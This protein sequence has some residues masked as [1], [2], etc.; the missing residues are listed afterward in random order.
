M[1]TGIDIVHVPYKAMQQAMLDA[2]TGQIQLSYA[3]SAQI[4]P[5]VSAGKVKPIAILGERRYPAW[6]AVGT[7]RDSLPAYEPVPS[8]TACGRPQACRS[9][10]SRG[11]P[12]S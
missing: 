9:R 1:R 7:F 10:S 5:M 12:P 2:S 6:P 3:L 4:A 11:F 8:W